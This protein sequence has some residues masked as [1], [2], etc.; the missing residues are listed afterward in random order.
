M[1]LHAVT[2]G[3]HDTLFNQFC[4]RIDAVLDTHAFRDAWQ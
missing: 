1:L 4:F 3:A 2:H